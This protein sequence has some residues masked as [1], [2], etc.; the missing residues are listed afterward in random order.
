MS[1]PRLLLHSLCILLAFLS[2]YYLFYPLPWR[3]KE[4]GAQALLLSD[5]YQATQ[6]PAAFQS[7]PQFT[8]SQALARQYPQVRYYPDIATL[9]AAQAH[10][11]TYTL[12]GHGLPP[13]LLATA[14]SSFVLDTRF[15]QAPQGLVALAWPAVQKLQSPTLL[16]LQSKRN[17]PTKATLLQA[18]G[19]ADTL[20]LP[21]GD[22]TLH[23]ALATLPLSGRGQASLLYEGDSLPIPLQREDSPKIRTLLWESSPN[24]ELRFLKNWLQEV[25][26]PGAIRTGI[27]RFQTQQERFNISQRLALD[28]LSEELLDSFD[29][30]I[31]DEAALLAL[32]PTEQRLLL[33]Q[34]REKGLGLLILVNTAF[35]V[36][37]WPAGVL[38]TLRNWA[39]NTERKVVPK[40]SFQ[41][42]PQDIPLEAAPVS[43]GVLRYPLWTDA[44]G[45]LLSA[46][47][48]YG[49]G[50]IGLQSLQNTFQYRLR[51]QEEAYQRFW[52]QLLEALSPPAA[53][54]W[55]AHFPL[56]PRSKQAFDIE[57]HA[58]YKPDYLLLKAEIQAHYD[59]IYLESKKGLFEWQGSY[60]TQEA[61]WHEA[62]L[63]EDSTRYYF[64]VFEE[65]AWA[66]QQAQR[67][68]I[69]TKNY[70]MQ[71][72]S[73]TTAALPQRLSPIYA[74][75]IFIL[76]MA[77]LW[78]EPKLPTPSK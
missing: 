56:V 66:A 40:S 69:S 41:V 67:D 73:T 62:A 52:A 1:R 24:T 15:L 11:S 65:N 27:S 72:P 21:S 19:Q 20:L 51:G 74:F 13:Q 75:I 26:Y 45:Q 12:F 6:V 48:H 38:P 7:L 78:I 31:A 18:N 50:R 63:S 2:L 53:R 23:I 64:Y 76:S 9:Q 30:M 39:D 37:T 4:A 36:P 29:M 43:L 60:R 58:A 68:F 54:T 16:S 34:I 10:I 46:W 71:Q 55:Q 61:G 70:A 3:S 8:L 28:M 44:Q 22:T 17:K 35:Q 14:D 77:V 57:V 5:G 25:G 49:R 42:L 47:Q 59:T 32:S 33:K